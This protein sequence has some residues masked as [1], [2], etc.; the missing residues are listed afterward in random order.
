MIY[1]TIHYIFITELQN[2]LMKTKVLAQLIRTMINSNNLM[3]I[4]NLEVYK[5]KICDQPLYTYCII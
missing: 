5:V 3:N 1:D 2:S 4:A